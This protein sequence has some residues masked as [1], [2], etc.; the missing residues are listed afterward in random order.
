MAQ[1]ENHQT[2]IDGI[3]FIYRPTYRDKKT[4]E[5]KHQ[6]VWWM[7]YNTD[8]GDIRKSTRQRDQQAA[9][10]EL[11]RTASKRVSGEIA[12][13]APERV[14]FSRLFELLVEDYRN[15]K[16]A[17]LTDVEGYLRLHL[18]PFFGAMRVI[19]LRKADVE[20]FRRETLK[21]TSPASVNRYVSILRRALQLG[22]NEDPPLVIRTI[23]KWFGKLAEDNVRTGIVTREMYE[24]VLPH[25]APHVRTAFVIGWH[26]GM[27]RGEILGLRWDQVD[28]A[29]GVIHLSRSQ[30]KARKPRIAPIYGDMA[31]VLEMARA[32]SGACPYVIQHEGKPVR[33]IKTAWAAAFARAGLMYDTGRL[34]KSGEKL[35]KPKALFHDLRRTAATNMDAAGVSQQQIMEIVGWE[36]PEMLRR[37]H[38]G[39]VKRAVEEGRKIEDY[40]ARQAVRRQPETRQ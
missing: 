20:R 25:M 28:L 14:T 29:A 12:D 32:G 22:A 2:H 21:T 6:A 34:R 13:T 4:G 38:I 1:K 26:L 36:T 8:D 23:P 40:M 7:A 30:T 17:S 37:Y 19:D 24:A 33:S 11:I 27:R 10:N 5:L 31:A 18:R 15:R 9:F 39:S 3:G 35:I 16:L